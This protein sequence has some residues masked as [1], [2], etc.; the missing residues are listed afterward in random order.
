MLKILKKIFKT[1]VLRNMFL[2]SLAMQEQKESEEKFRSLFNQASDAIFL[3]SLSDGGLTIED[4]NDG[5]I[6]MHGYKREEMLGKPIA[7]LDDYETKRQMPGRI[8]KLL[9]GKSLN[10]EAIHV[11]KDGSKFP[12][13]VSAQLIHIDKKPYVLAID[14]DISERKKAEEAL[15]KSQTELS[16]L[17][18]V[19]S[20]ISQTIDMEKLFNIIFETITSLGLMDFESKGGI[21]IIEEDRM[22]LVAHLGHTD[23]FIDLHKGMRVGTCLC[24]LAAETG[25]II[26]SGNSDTD[27]RHTIRYPGMESH[28]HV[29]IPLNARGMIIGILYFYLKPDLDI[30]ESKLKLLYAIGNQIGVSIDNAKLYEDAKKSSLHDPLTG[31]ANRRLMHIV[32]SRGLAEA[33]RTNKP[34]SVIMLDIDFF[35]DFNDTKGHPAGDV[36][37]SELS[38]LILKESREVDLVVRYGGEEFLILLPDTSLEKSYEA[39]ERL[40]KVVESK[41]EV[42]ISLGVASYSKKTVKE[43]DLIDKADAA[44]YKAKQNGRNRIET[45]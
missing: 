21:F 31:L 16:L 13:D 3:L 37:L 20:A 17:F 23:T 27:E 14:R 19:S 24:G 2:T 11:R 6:A 38:K 33:R 18:S 4:A 1:G 42:T 29:I 44:L 35:K 15:I 34:F 36:L 43:K 39:A 10:F 45:S 41:T 28:G 25:E 7:F 26:I 40:R 12:V 30:D 22:T 8:D 32:F 5:A 9:E